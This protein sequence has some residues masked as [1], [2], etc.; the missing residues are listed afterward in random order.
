M[1]TTL[2][3]VGDSITEGVGAS[4]PE[5]TSYVAILGRLLGSD[6]TALNFGRC[7]ATVMDPKNGKIDSYL[8]LSHYERA[9]KAAAD[10]A[11]HGDRVIVSIMLG[12]NDADV[13]DYGFEVAGERYYEIYHDDFIEKTLSI[14]G[15]FRDICPEAV[16]L[17]CKS[18]WSYDN[19]KHKDFG[20][21]ESVWR[22]QQ[23][24]YERM[25]ASGCKVTLLDVAAHTAPEALGD[26]I[27]DYFDDG[28]HPCDA[29]YE[30]MAAFFCD[31]IKKL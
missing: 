20:N 25:L 3:M 29:G 7:G 9:K 1:H 5:K 21:L 31:T 11:A 17:Y 22:Y 12:T 27:A 13:I 15:S 26:G 4:D 6:Y 16:F 18:P 24:I 8:R 2:I 14:V 23:E 19:V 10:A 28:L 30:K